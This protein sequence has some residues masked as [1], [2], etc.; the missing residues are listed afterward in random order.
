MFANRAAAE[1]AD[2]TT[3]DEE[4]HRV[5]VAP[6]GCEWTVSM[7]LHS[8]TFLLG[9]RLGCG[10]QSA[11]I[12]SHHGGHHG[13][14]PPGHGGRLLASHANTSTATSNTLSVSH[15]DCLWIMDEAA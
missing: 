12:V 8:R 3:G 14:D 9:L 5:A 11:T 7:A 4:G 10:P 13:V 15:T 1:P 2:R 6:P